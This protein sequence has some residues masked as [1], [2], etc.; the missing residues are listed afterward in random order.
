MDVNDTTT[1]VST[2]KNRDAVFGFPTTK[3]GCTTTMQPHSLTLQHMNHDNNTQ[4]HF[5]KAS[6]RFA[7]Q[8][9]VDAIEEQS[10]F[11]DNGFNATSEMTSLFLQST[12]LSEERDYSSIINQYLT[13]THRSNLL[14]RDVINSFK[15]SIICSMKLSDMTGICVSMGYE[16]PQEGLVRFERRPENV[17]GDFSEWDKILQILS[18]D[19]ASVREYLLS[20]ESDF[21][22]D[23]PTIK[24]VMTTLQ[25]VGIEDMSTTDCLKIYL[26]TNIK[27]VSSLVAIKAFLTDTMPATF[28]SSEAANIFTAC[29]A[30]TRFTPEE[31]TNDLSW[32]MLNVILSPTFIDNCL[33]FMETKNNMLAWSQKETTKEC[34]EARRPRLRYRVGLHHKQRIAAIENTVVGRGHDD[35]TSLGEKHTHIAPAVS[36]MSQMHEDSLQGWSLRARVPPAISHKSKLIGYVLMSQLSFADPTNA[37]RLH[38]ANDPEISKNM[39]LQRVCKPHSVHIIEF[40]RLLTVHVSPFDELHAFRDDCFSDFSYT[41]SKDLSWL[42]FLQLYIAIYQNEDVWSQVWKSFC[43]VLSHQVL[44]AVK[45]FKSSHEYAVDKVAAICMQD[46]DSS[47]KGVTE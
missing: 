25:E 5:L 42:R 35:D 40:L 12:K 3:N 1:P 6:E 44:I 4:N 46:E 2:S 27:N 45:N 7:E 9:D 15:R 8:I 19:E 10:Q 41:D 20:V 30:D 24:F 11:M 47:R 13:F 37:L 36:H 21:G 26:M 22:N 28:N 32:F 16:L 14:A 34:E 39:L 38:F 23:L 31:F 18:F 17:Y 43:G 33:F 29:M